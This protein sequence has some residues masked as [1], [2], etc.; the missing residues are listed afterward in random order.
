MMT[1]AKEYKTLL[2]NLLQTED[3]Q[4][5]FQPIFDVTTSEPLGYEA[6]TRGPLGHPLQYPNVLFE[7]AHVF[8]LLSELELLCRK[9]AF[10]RFSELQLTGKLFINVSPH[11]IEQAAFFKLVDTIC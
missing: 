1:L 7:A 4:T 9:L 5:V 11:T 8:G 6:L 10:Q 2:R 3:L